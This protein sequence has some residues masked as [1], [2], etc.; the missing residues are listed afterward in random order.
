MKKQINFSSIQEEFKSALTE[1]LASCE[2]PEEP[3]NMNR[4]LIDWAEP[5]MLTILMD[6]ALGNQ[7]KVAQW[8]GI[9]RATLRTKLKR[10]GLNERGK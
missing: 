2:S 3:A 9:N 6:R 7:S 5:I 8:L 4:Q 10:H 1:Y